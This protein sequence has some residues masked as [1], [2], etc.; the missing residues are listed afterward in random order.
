M[1]SLNKIPYGNP[2]EVKYFDFSAN[3]K[4]QMYNPVHNQERTATGTNEVSSLLQPQ[5]MIPQQP[6][7]QQGTQQQSS[8]L[9]NPVVD[10]QNTLKFLQGAQA[11][12]NPY[13]KTLENKYLDMASLKGS[14]QQGANQQAFL[15]QGLDP[16]A[17]NVGNMMAQRQQDATIGN[18]QQT[19][20]EEQA[21]SQ[22]QANQQ[23]MQLSMQTIDKS[24]NDLL[25]A[26]GTK[27]IAK[28][29]SL[30]SGLYGSELDP[31]SIIQKNIN[32]TLSSYAQIP[33]LS[34]EEALNLAETNGD[35]EY[36]GITKEQAMAKMKPIYDKSNPISKAETEYKNMLSQ[37]LITQD[38]Y[39]KM[40][41]AV[42]FSLTNPQDLDIKDSYIVKDSSGKV[43]G[44]FLSSE[45][46]TAFMNKNQDKY[47]NM[48]SKFTKDGYI[49]L[50]GD[51]KE[52]HG[53]DD[54][55]F[56]YQGDKLYKIVDG[57]K[58]SH[59]LDTK[60]P[61][62]VENMNLIKQF[63]DKKDPNIIK[64][65]DSQE[66]LAIENFDEIPKEFQADAL[67]LIQ[68]STKITPI[69]Y[70]KLGTEVKTLGAGKNK[71]NVIE[72]FDSLNKGSVV[73]INDG[74]YKFVG[75]SER[76]ESGVFD[77]SDS[78]VYEFIDLNTGKVF[79]IDAKKIK[80]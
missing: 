31:H 1:E 72:R 21:K 34:L 79:R 62:S 76:E 66:S 16:T 56:L 57:K 68:N 35:L 26:G 33:G 13:L 2:N 77:Y 18:V 60:D 30:Y 17:T 12:E 14:A 73:K 75:K 24:I 32:S 45:E 59:A 36:L 50:K 58:V 49:G 28:A 7:Q 46:A 53:K 64:L 37:G 61:F 27:N 23:L 43:I 8:Q 15:Q 78:M 5:Q 41:S 22:Q 44:N 29:M 11:G 69:S 65:R 52:F 39:N 48:S 47:Q 19:F 6:K 40:M 20:V 3:S 70:E 51:Y 67:K 54:G 4:P 74:L 9:L 63:G 80:K 38:E 42:K 55:E 10:F 25:T 71:T